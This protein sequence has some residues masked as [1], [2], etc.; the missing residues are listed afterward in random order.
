MRWQMR[1]HTNKFKIDLTADRLF[2]DP[3]DD[4]WGSKWEGWVIGYLLENYYPDVKYDSQVE[5]TLEQLKRI[6]ELCDK[7]IKHI[8]SGE[9]YFV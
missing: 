7:R 1:H 5:L 3:Q 9:V 4:F 8:E 6:R 2:D